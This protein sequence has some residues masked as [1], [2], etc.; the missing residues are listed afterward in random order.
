M[1]CRGCLAGAIFSQENAY[2][3]HHVLGFLEPQQP[4][5]T[6]KQLENPLKVQRTKTGSFGLSSDSWVVSGKSLGGL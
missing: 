6:Q 3:L 4:K 5:Q 1:C 2:P